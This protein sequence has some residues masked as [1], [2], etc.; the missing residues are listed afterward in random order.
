[1]ANDGVTL[2]ITGL[3]EAIE[4][5][6]QLSEQ[7][8][9]KL[10]DDALDLSAGYALQ[11][12]KGNTPIDTGRLQ[13]SEQIWILP[14]IRLIGPDNTKANYAVFVEYGHHTR[15]GSWV[16]GQYYVNRTAVEILPVVRTFFVSALNR[17]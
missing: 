9:P 3:K 7:M 17:M 11:V 6:V 5:L 1:M 16:P 14:G 15:S 4:N 8:I 12:L 2:T 10:I 13:E